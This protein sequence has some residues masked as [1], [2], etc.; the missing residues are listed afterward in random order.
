MRCTRIIPDYAFPG[1]E[2]PAI[3]TIVAGLIGVAIVFLAM[4]GARLAACV[5]A[6]APERRV[7]DLDRYVPRQ[8]A[9][10]A[11]DARLKFILTVAFIVAVSLLP[12]GAYLALLIAW[13]AVVDAVVVERTSVPCAPPAAR[14]S[15]SRSCSRPCRSCS[16]D[17]GIRWR[18]SISDRCP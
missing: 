11:A 6:A 9:L 7:L 15:R 18:P 5:G 10:H 8:S 2:D 12:V 3:S 13:L 1:L 14:S 17:P 4:V 16:P